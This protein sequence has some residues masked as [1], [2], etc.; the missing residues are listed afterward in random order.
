MTHR[1]VSVSVPRPP[2]TALVVLGQSQSP[3]FSLIGRQWLFKM[4]GTRRFTRQRLS[5]FRMAKLFTRF[6]DCVSWLN[7]EKE[8]YVMMLFQLLIEWIQPSWSWKY[9]TAHG[10]R[11]DTNVASKTCRHC[12]VWTIISKEIKQQTWIRTASTTKVKDRRAIDVSAEMPW[13]N[14]LCKHGFAFVMHLTLT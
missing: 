13:L 4:S 9:L 1:M 14:F 2:I 8:Q 7:H 6:T 12:L 11:H 3:P 10:V 5:S